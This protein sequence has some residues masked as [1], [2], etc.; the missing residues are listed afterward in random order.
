MA[1]RAGLIVE[2]QACAAQGEAWSRAREAPPPEAI[3]AVTKRLV[4]A[5][6]AWHEGD[7]RFS[8]AVRRGFLRAVE[9]SASASGSGERLQVLVG[10]LE[11]ARR[12]GLRTQLRLPPTPA[13][14]ATI[15]DEEAR[16]AGPRRPGSQVL[17]GRAPDIAP[18]RK[19]GDRVLE[20]RLGEAR[21]E[22]LDHEL[23]VVR[24]AF[25]LGRE[26]VEAAERLDLWAQ[27]KVGGRRF[28]RVDLDSR[29]NTVCWLDV[30]AELGRYQSA[31]RERAHEVAKVYRAD[32][33]HLRVTRDEGL[34]LLRYGHGQ[35]YRAHADFYTAG[36]K[37][38]VR[39]VSLV[40][41][42]NDDFDGGE[43]HFPRQGF[44]FKP[45]AGSM[46]LFPAFFTHVH[47]AKDVIRG[48][49]YSV[50]TWFS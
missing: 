45:E 27:A 36:P 12:S 1:D 26:L 10:Q 44:T 30:H 38:N 5:V 14:A 17:D 21:F 24:G 3:H 18:T 42:L 8:A 34:Q 25:A 31:L 32:N 7:S 50:A 33:S 11:A 28:S 29:N 39:L 6:L 20:G 13:P 9:A 16:G 23:L 19:V 37:D 15:R 40:A 48:V 2:L 4:D 47:E 22:F 43:L 41:F 49:K 46:I 35:H